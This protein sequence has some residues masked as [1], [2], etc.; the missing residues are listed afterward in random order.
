MTGNGHM[1]LKRTALRHQRRIWRQVVFWTALS[2][3]CPT[4]Y[5]AS[6]TATS[7]ATILT[8]GSLVNRTD[9]RFG[10]IVAGATS[11]TVTIV[12]ATNTR[13]TTGGVQAAGGAIGAADFSALSSPGQFTSVQITLPPSINLV[14]TTAGAPNM[15]VNNFN[16]SGSG[17]LVLNAQGFY[18]FRIGATLNVAANQPI[19]IYT[20]TFT[21]IGTFQ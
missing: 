14:R 2:S 19:G 9:L 13:T 8:S 12:S 16:G 3:A 17:S 15:L 7:T 21:V 6:V 11:G 20:G 1:L 18:D 5:A 10:K 4:A